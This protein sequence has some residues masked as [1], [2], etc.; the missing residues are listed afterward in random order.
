MTSS[1]PLKGR[2]TRP[3]V[4]VQRQRVATVAAQ[5]FTAAGTASVSIGRICTAAGISRPTFYRCFADKDALVAHLYAETVAG[6]VQ[7]NLADVLS[8]SGQGERI[9]TALDTLLERIFEHPD[10]ARFALTEASDPRTPAYRH[11]HQQFAAAAARIEAALRGRGHPPPP[12]AA[13]V[14]LMVACQWL[15]LDALSSSSP[16]ARPDA[17]RAMSAMVHSLFRR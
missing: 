10:Q 8:T 6:P 13:L 15:T 3:G 1:I 5:L 12:R 4:D 17:R 7:L 14:A 11:A 16:S 2:R 9:D